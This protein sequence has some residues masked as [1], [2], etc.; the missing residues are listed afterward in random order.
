MGF[1]RSHYIFPGKKHGYFFL[2]IPVNIP[3]LR[4]QFFFFEHGPDNQ[5]NTQDTIN[6]QSCGV[7]I[8]GPLYLLFISFTSIFDHIFI[9]IN[10][11]IYAFDSTI[12]SFNDFYLSAVIKNKGY[13][14]VFSADIS[15]RITK[16]GVIVML[17]K[18][19]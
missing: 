18:P 13:S 16:Q 7:E 3:E 11:F 2:V 1:Y 4:K 17:T 6:D 14:F 10:I 12:C 19:W 15:L 5:V 9:K 8:V